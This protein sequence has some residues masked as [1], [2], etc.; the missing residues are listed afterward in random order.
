MGSAEIISLHNRSATQKHA[1]DQASAKN[2]K[3]EYLR[4][5]D[6]LLEIEAERSYFEFDVPSFHLYC[7]ELLELSPQIAKDFGIVVR[8]TLEVPQLAEAIRSSGLTISK[9]RKICSVLTVENHR[10]WIDLA[11]QCS[12]REI[13]RAVA[14]AN[15]K[16]A[17]HETLKYVSGER[18]EFKTGVSQEWTELLQRT[19]D[20]LSQKERRR[21]VSSEEALFTLMSEYCRKNDPV[22]K[23]KRVQKAIRD[24]GDR[25]K[26]LF[27]T[28][29]RY[30]PMTVEHFVSLRDQ[31][32]CTHVD[33]RGKRC[34][35]KR[36]LEKHHR[37]PP[38]IYELCAGLTIQSRIENSKT[39]ESRDTTTVIQVKSIH[40]TKYPTWL[41]R[42]GI[43][44]LGLDS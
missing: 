26:P 19:K 42:L 29:R 25:A 21:A 23:A 37:T 36:W 22:E 43:S 32:Q 30:R 3:S 6:I 28:R 9:A 41:H 12:C 44:V 7:V 2:I 27:Q 31:A 40:L 16:E 10:Q 11:L 14:Q 20:L 4:L 34:E 17:V 33:A 1:V 15:P 18:L 8:K 38:K 39:S 5:F 24:E 35:S 13:E